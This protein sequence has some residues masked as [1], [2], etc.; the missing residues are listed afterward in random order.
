MI[1]KDVYEYAIKKN[2][3]YKKKHDNLGYYGYENII[4]EYNKQQNGEK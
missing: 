2:D 1:T 4:D 3:A